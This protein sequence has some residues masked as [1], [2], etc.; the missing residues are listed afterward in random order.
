MMGTVLGHGQD[1]QINY[2]ISK[3]ET[4]KMF[5]RHEQKY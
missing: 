4:G 3:E 2:L 5:T 1:Q